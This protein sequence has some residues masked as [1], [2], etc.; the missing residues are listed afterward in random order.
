MTEKYPFLFWQL[1]LVAINTSFQE[2][3]DFEQHYCLSREAALRGGAKKII[4]DR[5]F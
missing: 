2:Y 5:A 4:L 3:Y 1:R